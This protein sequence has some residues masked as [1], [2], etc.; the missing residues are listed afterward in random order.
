MLT[1]AAHASGDRGWIVNTA[2]ILGFRGLAAAG[3]YCASKAAVVNLVRCVWLIVVLLL[4][5]A[6]LCFFFFF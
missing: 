3:E 1:Q 5:A 6:D 2:S 4:L